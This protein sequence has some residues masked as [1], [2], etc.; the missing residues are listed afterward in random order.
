MAILSEEDGS[1][2]KLLLVGICAVAV[3]SSI[4]CSDSK[5]YDTVLKTGMRN[6]QRADTVQRDLRMMPFDF[7]AI[8]GLN[9]SQ[10]YNDYPS[11]NY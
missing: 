3:L 7:D 10:S 6:R 4:G 1:M 5:Y 2:K 8:F 11:P 9:Y